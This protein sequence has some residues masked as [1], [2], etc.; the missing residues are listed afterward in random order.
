ML[1][2]KNGKP[3]YY[4][5]ETLISAVQKFIIK[6]VIQYADRKINTTKMIVG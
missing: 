3:D 4:F 2:T 5:M 1:P 6:D